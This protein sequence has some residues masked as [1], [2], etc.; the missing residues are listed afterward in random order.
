[1]ND[2]SDSY[3]NSVECRVA[4]HKSIWFGYIQLAISNQKIG[5]TLEDVIKIKRV[6][7]IRGYTYS[8]VGL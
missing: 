3:L 1:M 4:V 7:E 6:Q 2:L 5:V 8:Y